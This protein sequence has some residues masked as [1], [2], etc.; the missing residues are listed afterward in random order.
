LAGSRGLAADYLVQ[1]G[2]KVLEKNF[3]DHYG[4]IDIIAR[5]GRDIVFVEV[6]AKSTH[7]YGHG[8][9]MVSA[10]KQNKIKRTAQAYLLQE[11]ISSETSIRIDV[12]SIDLADRKITWFKNAVTD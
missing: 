4:E 10:R 2:A 7:L 9:E 11:N 5:D 6:K 3:R 1:K 12:V 8:F